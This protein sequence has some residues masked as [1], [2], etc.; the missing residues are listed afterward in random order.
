MTEPM[1]EAALR[2][3]LVDYLVT[4]VGCNPEEVDVEASMNDLGVG[5]RDAVVLSG[6]L[7]ELLGRPVSPVEFWQHPTI[8]SLAKF[9]TGAESDSDDGT[10]YVPSVGT[11]NEPIAVIGLGC[12]LPGG[13]AGPEALW[14]LL[15]E[16]GNTVGEV[17]AERWAAFDD[18]TA[19]TAAAMSATTRWGSFL[20]EIDTFDPDTKPLPKRRFEDVHA[21]AQ[22]IATR[23]AYRTL[24][25]YGRRAKK[26]ALTVREHIDAAIKAAREGDAATMAEELYRASRAELEY[27]DDPSTRA[28]RKAL[29]GEGWRGGPRNPAAVSVSRPP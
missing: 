2:N 20:E 14:Q 9:L 6:E 5:S 8:D 10:V 27:G 3:W 1:D 21:I 15:A 7:S 12:R 25:E 11:L 13:I 22:A 18:G 19:E 26:D 28:A 23:A 17:P 4:N 16:G 24:T 29:L